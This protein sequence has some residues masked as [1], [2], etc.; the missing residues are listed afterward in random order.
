MFDQAIQTV[1]TQGHQPARYGNFIGG[2]WVDPIEGRWFTDHSPING[3][4][5]AEIA[6]S[7]PRSM[8]RM[9]P[10]SAGRRCRRRS[11]P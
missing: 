11:G 3:R 9:P 7:T 4:P 1:R 5:L 6:Q 2:R 8:L 10:G